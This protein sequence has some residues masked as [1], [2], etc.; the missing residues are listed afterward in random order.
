VE[1]VL[2]AEAEERMPGGVELE[3]VDALTEPVV[4]AQDGRVLVREA[5]ELER[6]A[7]AESPERRAALLLA[8]ASLPAQRLD[9]RPVLGEQVV[10]R[11]RRRLVRG[12]EVRARAA[13]IGDRTNGVACGL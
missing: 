8:G 10:A 12:V 5:A 4:R 1:A 13:S 7:A 3:L 9:E 2:D 11:E 6:L